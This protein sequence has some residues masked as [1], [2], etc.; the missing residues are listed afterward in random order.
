MRDDFAVCS[1]VAVKIR[2]ACGGN[3]FAFS[4]LGV[5]MHVHV[6]GEKMREVV[7]DETFVKI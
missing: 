5:C 4:A 6:A 2:L 3:K 1:V 7:T